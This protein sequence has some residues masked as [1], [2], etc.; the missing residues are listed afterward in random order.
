[1]KSHPFYATKVNWNCLY[2]HSRGNVV[3]QLVRLM[4]KGC[5]TLSRFET[6]I[7]KGPLLP[8]ASFLR[9]RASELGSPPPV[10]AHFHSHGRGPDF[11]LD[12]FSLLC[13]YQPNLPAPASLPTH[14][15]CGMLPLVRADASPTRSADLT[16]LNQRHS[17]HCKCKPFLN[18]AS[19]CPLT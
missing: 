11:S 14:S 7:S 12:A 15:V 2:R 1:M 8:E 10:L 17:Q 3:S 19:T 18:L 6:W 13:H 4:T 9:S 16:L 5:Q